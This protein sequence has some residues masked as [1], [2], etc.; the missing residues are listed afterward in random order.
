V[1]FPTRVTE[2]KKKEI[3]KKIWRLLSNVEYPKECGANF[4]AIIVSI[5]T[6]TP[7]CVME[8]ENPSVAVNVACICDTMKMEWRN[9]I[10]FWHIEIMGMKDKLWRV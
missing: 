2:S 3:E 6:D 5:S 1:Y 4:P 10:F 7:K 9:L 8:E